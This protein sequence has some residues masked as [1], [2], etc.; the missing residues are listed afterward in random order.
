MLARGENCGTLINSKK[1]AVVSKEVSK[2]EKFWQKI[3]KAIELGFKGRIGV[4]D[5]LSKNGE[6]L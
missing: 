4:V 5:W 2:L 6:I 1:N 3:E